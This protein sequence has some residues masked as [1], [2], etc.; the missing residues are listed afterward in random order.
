MGPV[1]P[2]SN[3][4]GFE[5]MKKEWSAKARDR[6]VDLYVNALKS[7]TTDDLNDKIVKAMADMYRA[8]WNDADA[9]FRAMEGS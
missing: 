9:M 8:G 6:H 2:S 5:M 4:W 3:H 1:M 7:G